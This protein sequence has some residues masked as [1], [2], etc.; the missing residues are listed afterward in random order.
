MG[1]GEQERFS[2]IFAKKI[3]ATFMNQSQSTVAHGFGVI[4]VGGG[5]ESFNLGA[6]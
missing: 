3:Y 4:Q 6:S 1:L 2:Y 5:G